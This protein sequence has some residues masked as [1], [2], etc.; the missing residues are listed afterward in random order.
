M[1]FSV[2]ESATAQIEQ[3]QICGATSP[4]NGRECW[5]RLRNSVRQTDI[6]DVYVRVAVVYI[7]GRD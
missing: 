1:D 4:P 2:K 6:A 5:Y 3:K 7:I